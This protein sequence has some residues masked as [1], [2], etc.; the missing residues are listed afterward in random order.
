M[1]L[2][3]PPLSGGT[4]S[5]LNDAGIE[6]FEGDFARNVVRE[7][8]Q[9]SLDAAAAGDKPILV[10]I[11]RVSL[12]RSD[13]PFMPALEETLRA[14]RDYWRDHPKAKKFFTTALAAAGRKEIDAIK[15]SDFNTT[16]VDG[17]D[18]DNTGRWFGLV[19]SRGVSNQDGDES[20]GAFGIGKDAPLAG[21]QFRTV[22]YSTRT[23]DGHTAFQ[24]VC[25]LVTHKDGNGELTQ[26]TGFIGD[27][28]AG[29]KL[30]RAVR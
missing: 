4:V 3:F 19:K 18:D 28:D 13:L 8:A 17:S 10:R 14:C 5:G 20:G 25:R 2:H 15:I 27:F 16:G 6:T 21:S 26:G 11:G 29:Q 12:V 7:C 1:K 30:S 24:G 9:N 23:R 22:L